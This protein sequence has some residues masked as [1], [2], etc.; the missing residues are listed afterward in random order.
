MFRNLFFKLIY[1]FKPPWDTGISPPELFDFIKNNPAGAAIDLGCGTGTNLISLAQA[2]WDVTVWISCPGNKRAIRKI[3]NADVQ[4]RLIVGAVTNLKAI[5]NQF[6][7]ALDLDCFHSLGVDKHDYYNG[8]R[9]HLSS[10]WSLVEVRH[11]Q[12]PPLS[13]PELLRPT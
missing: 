7:L 5:S 2:G 13:D 12:T 11:S 4:A 8:I 10:W 1:Y 6:D 9:P 3:N